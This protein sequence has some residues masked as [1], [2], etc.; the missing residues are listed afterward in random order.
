MI[1]VINSQGG[2][3]SQQNEDLFQGSTGV[4]TINLIAP[5]ATNVIFKAVFEMPDGSYKPDIDG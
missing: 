2:L 3:V 4:N 1:I 5:F